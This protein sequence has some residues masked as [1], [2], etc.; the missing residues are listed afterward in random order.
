MYISNFN[1][2]SHTRRDNEASYTV[3]LKTCAWSNIV[4]SVIVLI[5]DPS[6]G[7]ALE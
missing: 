2:L 1:I 3:I 7:D 6:V 5:S 4:Q